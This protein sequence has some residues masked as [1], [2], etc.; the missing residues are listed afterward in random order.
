MYSIIDIHCRLNYK[1][2]VTKLVFKIIY[3]VIIFRKYPKL[4]L[5]SET[6]I[7]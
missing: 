6:Y 2:N 5:L 3:H 7:S 1:Y 4:I